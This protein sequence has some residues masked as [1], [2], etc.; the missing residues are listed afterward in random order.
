MHHEESDWTKVRHRDGPMCDIRLREETGGPEYRRPCIDS[1]REPGHDERMVF[2]KGRVASERA[3]PQLRGKGRICAVSLEPL[4]DVLMDKFRVW[5]FHRFYDMNVDELNPFIRFTKALVAS[6]GP[7][8]RPEL[9]VL[10][11]GARQ[12]IKKRIA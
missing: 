7:I 6:A 12:E 8:V 1:N 11:P 5:A 10:W 3:Q 2:H 9:L 4:P